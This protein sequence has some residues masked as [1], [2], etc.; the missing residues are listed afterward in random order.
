MRFDFAR[1]F[2]LSFISKSSSSTILRLLLLLL[3][4]GFDANYFA[5]N[6]LASLRT[7][8]RDNSSSRSLIER[9]SIRIV[10]AILE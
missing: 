10:I 1:L 4:Q 8:I 5:Y 3:G 7:Y 9:I 6:L 2:T